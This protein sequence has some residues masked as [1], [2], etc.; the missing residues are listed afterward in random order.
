[1]EMGARIKEGEGKKVGGGELCCP[2]D[3]AVQREGRLQQVI[4]YRAGVRLGD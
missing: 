3:M 1:M 2:L 4:C